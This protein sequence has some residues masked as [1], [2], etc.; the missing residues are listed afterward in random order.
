VLTADRFLFLSSSLMPLIS[1]GKLDE[2]TEGPGK[3]RRSSIQR[4]VRK[5]PSRIVVV[6]LIPWR[7]SRPNPSLDRQQSR[8][9]CVGVGTCHDPFQRKLRM[10]GI[11]ENIPFPRE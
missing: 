11:H 8:V 3:L 4:F 5:D 1:A 10:E 9:E 2:G 6:S 7:S